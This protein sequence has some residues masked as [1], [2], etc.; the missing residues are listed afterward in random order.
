MRAVGLRCEHRDDTPCVDD[1]H[2]RLSWWL[3]DGER[4]TAYRVRVGTLWDSG[5][6]E[7]A[8]TVDVPYGGPPLP[9]A[10]ELAWT[11]EVWEG[12]AS[13]VSAEPRA[14]ARDPPSG[15]GAGSAATAS[16]TPRCPCP[17]PTRSSTRATP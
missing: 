5:R 17:A 8:Q 1:P 11:V 4:Q 9:A 7:S 2:P 13:E 15:R 10:A 16:P 6:I 14:S 12:G 3:E